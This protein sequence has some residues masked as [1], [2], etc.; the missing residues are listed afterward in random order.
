VTFVITVS[1]ASVTIGKI[2]QLLVNSRPHVATRVF[3]F[4]LRPRMVSCMARGNEVALKLSLM[5]RIDV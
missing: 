2:V 3:P 4:E 5:S 1:S